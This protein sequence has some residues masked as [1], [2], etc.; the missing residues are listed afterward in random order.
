M[1]IGES[2]AVPATPPATDVVVHARLQIKSISFSGNHVVEQDTRGDFAP[3]EWV[4]GRR[5]QW[6]IC[7]TRNANV[8]LTARFEVVG[9]P[10]ATETVSIR[11]TTSLAGS[12]LEWTGSVSVAPDAVE[13]VTAEI[14]S[15]GTL[16]NHVAYFQ[17]MTTA[18]E[19]QPPSEEWS[20][21]GN[22]NHL[23]Y[24]TLGDPQGTPAYWTLLHISCQN[25]HGATQP[26]DLVENTYRSFPGRSL[27]RRRDSV[28]LTYWNPNTT[29]VTN[30]RELL[31]RADGSGQ[32]GSWSEF[33]I[34]MYKVHGITAGK[35]VLVVRNVPV[36]RSSSIGFLVKN[37]DFVG[38][39]SLP[40][41]F[42]HQMWVE[43]VERPGVPGQR[44]PNPPPAFYNHFIV[45]CFN[46]LYDPS[47]G[48]GPIDTQSSWENSSIDG[49]FSGG[50][51]GYPKSANTGTN[52][53]EFHPI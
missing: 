6:P 41:P 16:P 11:G 26:T 7:Y 47:Y 2:V 3:P 12:T 5:R 22:S 27:T 49:L 13:V 33:L 30:T 37:W 34:D 18:W 42:T 31:A 43:C 32:C 28:G 35:K 52:L 50:A 51:C 17:R 1:E 21:A 14:T 44:N 36:W 53:L 4:R 19:A 10:S 39:G 38:A 9:A 23:V 15:S 20:G 45:K 29:N 24:L 46:K 25:A 8:R 40:A 48:S